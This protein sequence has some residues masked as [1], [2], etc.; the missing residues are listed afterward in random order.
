MSLPTLV[1]Q[2]V[3]FDDADLEVATSLGKAL[4]E[5]ITGP[6]GDPLA[7]GAGVPVLVA[8]RT[9]R[10]R[11]DTASYTALVPVLG[12]D[13]YQD[14]GVRDR[15]AATLQKWSQEQ[16]S[17]VLPLFLSGN[18]LNEETRLGLKVLRTWL[19]EP[20]DSRLSRS[21][22]EIVLALCRM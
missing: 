14:E 5:R 8:V 4:F 21:M 6:I 2:T 9:D 10:V 3:Y 7:H 11:L 19:D 1:V 22:D 20:A 12:S 13:A 18:W 15:V 16:K 17:L